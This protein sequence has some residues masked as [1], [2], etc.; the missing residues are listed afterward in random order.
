MNFFIIQKSTVVLLKVRLNLTLFGMLL[1]IM[2]FLTWGMRAMT[3]LGV[4]RHI[5]LNIS[6][7]LPIILRC[8]PRSSTPNKHGRQF[9]FE[10]MWSLDPS[11][12]DIIKQVRAGRCSDDATNNL[13]S[14]VGQCS[15]KLVQWNKEKFGHY[16]DANTGWF[17]SQANMRGAINS[18]AS[19]QDENVKPINPSV[20]NVNNLIDDR[21]GCWRESVIKEVFG[22]RLCHGAL[23]TRENTAKR[24]HG[25]NMSCTIC[26]H[27]IESDVHILLQCP[28]TVQVWEGSSTAKCL[29]SDPI[30]STRDCVE[31]ATKILD[32]DEL[33]NF[34]AI[35]WEIWNAR[36][37]FIFKRSDHHL[38]SLS[39]GVIDFVKNYR[40][41]QDMDGESKAYDQVL[42]QPP[43][44]GVLKL[45]FDRGKVGEYGRGWGFVVGSSDGDICMAAMQQSSNFSGPILGEAKACLCGLRAA[46]EQGYL[47]FAVKGDCLPLIH[48]LKNILID[49]NVLGC[50]IRDIFALVECF[51]FVS[52]SLVKR[53]DDRVAHDL[54]HWQPITHERRVWVDDVPERNVS[55]VLDDMYAFI[56]VNLI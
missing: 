40:A 19:L 14:K 31:R 50:I 45:N 5:N 33:G 35:I 51:K 28:L 26:G 54:A 42:W 11:C 44:M 13:L 22:W 52:F 15:E 7:H 8:Y 24:I 43:D 53:G 18:T 21:V 41:M 55:L 25:F 56:D 34:V 48:K 2:A 46:R 37:R 38:A 36:N 20:W 9:R 16:G 47:C 32:V 4:V 29:W 17:H 23:P 3:S 39:Y 49:D 27:Y 10:N 6:Y 1:W 30:R 12:T